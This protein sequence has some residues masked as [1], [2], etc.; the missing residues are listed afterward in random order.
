MVFSTLLAGPGNRL[1]SVLVFMFYATLLSTKDIYSYFVGALALFSLLKA[2]DLRGLALDKAEKSIVFWMLLFAS[3]SIAAT[4]WHGAYI[5]SFEVPV[6]FALSALLLVCLIKSPPRP[7]AFWAGLC[8]GA[9]SGLAVAFWKMWQVGEFKAFGFTGAIQFGNLAL[10]MAVL[11]MVGLCWLIANES[12]NRRLWLVL[13]AL[14][15]VCGLLGSY[16]SGTRGGWVA[17]P[18]FVLLFLLVYVRRHNLLGSGVLLAVLLTAMGFLAYKSPLIHERV[19]EAHRDLTEYEAHGSSSSSSLGARF[20]IW[21]AT[22]SMLKE[23]PMLGV[24][25]VQFRQQLQE[26]SQAGLIGKVPA[27]LAN[28]HNT[29]LEVWVL[30]GA[31]ALLSLIALMFSAVWYFFSYIRHADSVLRSY[32]LGGLCLVGGYAVYGQTQIML[33]RNNTLLF[34]LIT[35]AVLIGLMHQRRRT[36][37]AEASY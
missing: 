2:F 5:R 15:T 28:T 8:A 26:R 1:T 24:G 18:L 33:I 23:Q 14:G 34:F 6:K 7:A 27:G 22:W 3:V 11:Q 32:A 12:K 10:S 17:L 29:F 4:M 30:Y 37:V 35:L 19:Q 21:G 36:A 20:A 25:E 13:L 16:Y 31:V 9:V